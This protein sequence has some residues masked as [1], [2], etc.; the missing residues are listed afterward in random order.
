MIDRIRSERYKK[1]LVWIPAVLW[2]AVIFFLSAQDG[3]QSGQLSGSLTGMIYTFLVGDSDPEA[4][5][6]LE[7]TIRTLAHATAYFILALLLSYALTRS[8]Q[9]R[10]QWTGAV[11]LLSALYAATDEWHQAFV[12][13]R[14]CELKDF[15]V[16]M[17]GALAA[18]IFFVLISRV[19]NKPPVSGQS[20]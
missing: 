14:A 8:V 9:V 17:A 20:S 7:G 18:I 10:W 12:P 13:G 11:F 2:M 5:A 15:L 16:D 3:S 19:R 1:I 6:A 4:L